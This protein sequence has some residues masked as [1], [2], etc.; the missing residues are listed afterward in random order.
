VAKELVLNT[1]SPQGSSRPQSAA[2]TAAP[3]KITQQQLLS[4]SR[5]ASAQVRSLWWCTTTMDT[6][7]HKHARA[8][9]HTHIHTHTRTYIYI[10]KYTHTNED[11]YART[12]GVCLCVFAECLLPK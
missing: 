1:S 7:M 4:E 9:A 5:P 10:L 6:H 8:R 12:C 3:I 2:Q 11:I